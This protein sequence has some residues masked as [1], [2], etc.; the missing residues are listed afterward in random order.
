[1][2]D[3]RSGVKYSR[4]TAAELAH[5][6]SLLFAPGGDERKLRSA[7]GSAADLVVADLEDAVAPTEKAAARGAVAELRPPVV[8]INGADTE[9]FEEDLALVAEL[10]PDAVVLP[11]A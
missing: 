7:L 9:W 1:M 5:A 2:S 6:R 8:R 4:A 10:E 11:K 3:F